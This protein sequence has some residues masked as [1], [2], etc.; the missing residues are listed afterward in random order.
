MGWEMTAEE[1]VIRYDYGQRNFAGVEVIPAHGF[2]DLQGFNLQG[3][4]LRGSNL[5]SA[6]LTGADLTDADLTG[7]ILTSADLERAIIINASLHSANLRWT[8]VSKANLT[9]TCLHH[10]NAADASFC[11]ARVSY[12]ERAILANANFRG[13]AIDNSGLCRFGNLIWNTTMSDG[14]IVIGPQYGD[15]EGR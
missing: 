10:I 5:K 12:L 8:N 4:N 14:T 1:L 11:E 15:G 9:R 2:I 3:I 7:A 6:R 13:A